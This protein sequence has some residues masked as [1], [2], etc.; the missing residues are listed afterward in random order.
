MYT[1]HVQEM[2]K[3][4]QNTEGDNPEKKVSAEGVVH[5]PMDLIYTKGKLLSTTFITS[6]CI[7]RLLWG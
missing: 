6:S 1:A 5:Y 2:K 7:I 4:K 3:A